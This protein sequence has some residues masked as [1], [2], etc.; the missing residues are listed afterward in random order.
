MGK[1]SASDPKN[2]LKEGAAKK[3][4]KVHGAYRHELT[5]E[6]KTEI[7][8]AFELFDTYGSGTIDIRDFKVAL[9]ALGFEP[10]P[11]ELKKHIQDL[12]KPQ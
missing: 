11:K 3:K 6:Q 8:E 1:E 4:A 7:K 10:A 9:R 5:L 2:D 12:N